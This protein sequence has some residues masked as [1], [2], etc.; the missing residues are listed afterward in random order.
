LYH[1]SKKLLQA[2]TS[3]KA[4]FNGLELT[5]GMI[6]LKGGDLQEEVENLASPV[7]EFSIASCFSEPFFETKKILLVNM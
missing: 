5:R 6:C 7:M 2:N 3:I 4:K 1:Y